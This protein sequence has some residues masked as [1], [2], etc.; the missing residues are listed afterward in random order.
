[1]KFIKW[2]TVFLISFT[3]GCIV[4]LTFLQEPFKAWAPTVLFTYKTP[5]IPIYLYVL[6]AFVI[7]FLLGIFFAVY[8][9][10]EQKFALRKKNKEI[11]KLKKNLE[12]QH[13]PEVSANE[14]QMPSSPDSEAMNAPLST[15]TEGLEVQEVADK[16]RSGNN[17]DETNFDKEEKKS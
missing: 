7:G 13:L 15:D 4:I 1:M 17:G 11:Q 12:T 8:I 16:A 2:I 6:I 5:P 10:V 14:M 9:F 3:L